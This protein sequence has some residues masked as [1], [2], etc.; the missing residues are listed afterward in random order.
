MYAGLA[1]VLFAAALGITYMLIGHGTA[2]RSGSPAA[3]R[4]G[5]AAAP[6]KTAAR[7]VAAQPDTSAGVRAAARQF[8]ALYSAG[9]W[10]A[11]W[12][13]LAPSVQ[14]AV[15]AATWTA[16]HNGCPSPSEG[17]ARVIKSVTFDGTTAVVTETVAGALGKLA[18][19]SDAWTYSGGRWGFE[20]PASDMGVYKHGSVRA[21]IAAAKAA[22]DC[23][24]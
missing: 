23:A 10:R 2:P 14:R 20:L 13:D 7:S 1:G 16:V 8:Y 21:D 18:T 11:S 17:M 6:A 24:S 3:A 5:T 15:P 19:L 9:Q 4:S 12:A 22:G